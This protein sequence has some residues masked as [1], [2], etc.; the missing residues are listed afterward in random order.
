LS[1]IINVILL[2]LKITAAV[3]SGSLAIIASSLDSLLDLLSGSILF[4]ISRAINKPDPYKY[5]VSKSSLE[6]VGIIVFACVMGMTSLYILQDAVQTLIY[7]FTGSPKIISLDSF[8]IAILSATICI[9]L[10]LHIYCRMVAVHS[11]LV[12][13]LAQDHLN[14]VKTNIVAMVAALLASSF[15]TYWWTDPVG[16]FLLSAF[17]IVNWIGSGKDQ[18]GMLVGA[19]APPAV[20]GQLAYLAAHHDA[21]ILR[22]DKV[23]AYHFG[24]RYIVE[25]DVVLPEDMPLKLTHDIGESLEIKIEKMSIVERAF[26]HLDYEC[27]HQPEHKIVTSTTARR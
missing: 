13:A 26:V 21:R 18:I 5:P 8:S 9:K 3:Q 25:V 12:G 14:D 6:P 22:V 24:M 19:S 17:I 4:L 7:G 23:L 27:T 20:I 15:H 1:F 11:S 2:G 10:C 16:A